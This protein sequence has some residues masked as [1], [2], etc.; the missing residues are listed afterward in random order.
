MVFL[1]VY[2]GVIHTTQRGL[3]SFDSLEYMLLLVVS[4][5]PTLL[6]PYPQNLPSLL[7][8]TSGIWIMDSALP[9]V[10]W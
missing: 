10:I 1:L 4:S 7:F 5:P 2:S 6:C 8:C 3:G 9:A